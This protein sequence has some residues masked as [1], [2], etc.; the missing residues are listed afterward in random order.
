M[1]KAVITFTIIFLIGLFSW[2]YYFQYARGEFLLNSYSN[3]EKELVEI[4]EPVYF[5]YN[6]KWT[7]NGK[8]TINEIRLIKN[9]G[10][11]LEADDKNLTVTALIKENA[12]DK[13]VVT[14]ALTEKQAMEMGIIEKYKPVENYLLNT[15]EF[16]MVLKVTINDENYTNDISAIEIAYTILGSER[17]NQFLYEGFFTE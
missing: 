3:I 5:G 2:L 1:K 9:D 6:M 10:S 8:P 16:N 15:Q 4:N 11:Y 14:D 7:G 17:E 12:S 13:A